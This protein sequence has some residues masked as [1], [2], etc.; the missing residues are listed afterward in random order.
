M[1]DVAEKQSGVLEWLDSP[2]LVV[3]AFAFFLLGLTSLGVLLW[4]D[5]R[6]QTVRLDAIVAQRLREEQTAKQE[7]VDTCFSRA[8][9]G[10]ALRAVLLA[11]ERGIDD[12]RAKDKLS[13][14]RELS[15][16]NTPTVAECRQLAMKLNVVPLSKEDRRG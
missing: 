12:P 14:F 3:G 8:A 6:E 5:S 16:L 1:A 15:L 10:P 4:S 13:D 9:Q 7:Q 11:L 2:R